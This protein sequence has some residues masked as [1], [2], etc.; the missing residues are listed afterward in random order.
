MVTSPHR[1][2]AS[3]GDGTKVR[4]FSLPHFLL[5]FYH[6]FQ[7]EKFQRNKEDHDINFEGSTGR[8][9][10]KLFIAI[11]SSN[12][13]YFFLCISL[14]SVGLDGGHLNVA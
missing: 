10:S 13:H 7:L 14:W 11:F 12:Y 4:L 5:L 2:N 8:K 9:W 6:L 3:F 1:K